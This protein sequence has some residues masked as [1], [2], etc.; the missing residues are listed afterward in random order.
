MS[1]LGR[2]FGTEKAVNSVVESVR[3]GIDAVFYTDQEKAEDAAKILEAKIEARKQASEMI[4]EWVKNT[5]GQNLSRRIIALL[6][7]S[8]WLFGHGGSMGLSIASVWF[9]KISS[10]LLQ[11]SEML[12][13]YAD[14]MTGA[15]M[16]ILGFYFGA[17]YADKFVSAALSSMKK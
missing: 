6:I 2:L 8:T 4:V 11:S 14:S 9:D 13:Q 7:T 1:F 15:M 10:K 3:Q 5:Q 17:P 12:A 16:L